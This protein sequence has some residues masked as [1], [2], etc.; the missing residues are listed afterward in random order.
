MKLNKS[1]LDKMW[2]KATTPAELFILMIEEMQ[3]CSIDYDTRT[4]PKP[5]DQPK[6]VTAKMA[7]K[8][9]ASYRGQFPFQH[10]KNCLKKS[11]K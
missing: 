9:P 11:K 7:K 6:L 10:L 5:T 2:T 1:N 3:N 4:N 8:V